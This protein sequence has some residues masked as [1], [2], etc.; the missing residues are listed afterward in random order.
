MPLSQTVVPVRVGAFPV[1][2]HAAVPSSPFLVT[3]A[4]TG[5]LRANPVSYAVELVR[6]PK[7]SVGAIPGVASFLI[8]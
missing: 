5:N 2:S 8:P 6:A 7:G 3:V 1:P 4:T